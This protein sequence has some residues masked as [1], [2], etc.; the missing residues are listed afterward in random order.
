MSKKVSRL[1]ENQRGWSIASSSQTGL[2]FM[3]KAFSHLIF[4]LLLL[5]FAGL[6]GVAKAAPELAQVSVKLTEKGLAEIGRKD[7]AKAQR[8]LEEAMVADPANAGAIAGL[9]QVH[10]LRGNTSLARKYYASTLTV[11]PVN[12]LALGHLGLIEIGLGNRDAAADKLRRLQTL[13]PTCGET[14]A[15]QSALSTPAPATP[16]AKAP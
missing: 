16:S 13:C 10:E 12:I 2:F 3:G 1:D 5:A 9:G 8:Y 6:P 15:L 4:C 11:D 14:A 7:F